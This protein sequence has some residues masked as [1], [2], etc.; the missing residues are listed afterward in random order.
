GVAALLFT[1]SI[2]VCGAMWFALEELDNT[3]S[4]VSFV[5]CFQ[6]AVKGFP[7]AFLPVAVSVLAILLGLMALILPGLYLMTQYALVPYAAYDVPHL[8]TSALLRR[9]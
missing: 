9:S 2:L 6:Y 8:S 4:T 7:R 1:L 5:Q 3:A